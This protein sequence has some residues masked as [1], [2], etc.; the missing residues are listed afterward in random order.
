MAR[1]RRLNWDITMSGGLRSAYE[2]FEAA[3]RRHPNSFN[4]L[5]ID[6]EKPVTHASPWE[7]LRIHEKWN[8]PSVSDEHCHLMVLNVEAWILADV[9]TLTNYYGKGFNRNRIPG[10]PNVESIPKRDLEDALDEATRQTQKG[11]YNKVRHCAELLSR[12]SVTT[13][14]KKAP[15]CERLFATIEEKLQGLATGGP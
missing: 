7:H 10:D 4:I 3:I 8:N 11:R 13:V 5:L 9:E 12:L 6:A 2:D 15:H 1:A 14:R